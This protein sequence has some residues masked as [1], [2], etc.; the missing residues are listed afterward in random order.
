MMNSPPCTG[1]SL[2]VS[3]KFANDIAAKLHFRRNACVA[4][5]AAPK[6]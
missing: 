2:A 4:A 6:L 5:A 3:G 1:Y